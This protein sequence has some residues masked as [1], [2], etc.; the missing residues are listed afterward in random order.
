MPGPPT[1]ESLCRA[2]VLECANKFKSQKKAAVLSDV[3]GDEQYKARHLQYR[4]AQV[5][6]VLRQC[7]EGRAL[8]TFG[9]AVK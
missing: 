9:V 5:E 2:Q 6:L 4:A 8:E 7:G 3:K 1:P